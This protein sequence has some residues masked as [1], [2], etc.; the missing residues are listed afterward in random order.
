MYGY[1]LL[2]QGLVIYHFLAYVSGIGVIAIHNE[3]I[4]SVITFNI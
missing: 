3:A 4:M 2:Y 1:F